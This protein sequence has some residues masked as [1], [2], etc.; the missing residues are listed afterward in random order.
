MEADNGV[1][2]IGRMETHSHGLDGSI[3]I[4]SFRKAL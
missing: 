3:K 2:L 1:V 4:G